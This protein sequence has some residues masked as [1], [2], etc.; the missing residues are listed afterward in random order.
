MYKQTNAQTDM[1][2]SKNIQN[3]KNTRKNKQ[4]N[5]QR[6]VQAKKRMDRQT[7]E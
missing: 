6:N 7:N 4:R 1:Q 2:K 5:I 3:I